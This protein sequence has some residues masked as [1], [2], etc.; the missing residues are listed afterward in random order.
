MAEGAGPQQLEAIQYDGRALRILNQ[1]K[2]PHVVE[3]DDIGSLDDGWRAIREMRVGPPLAHMC[4]H[5]KLLPSAAALIPLMVDNTPKQVRGAPAIAIV[6]GLSLLVEVRKHAPYADRAELQAKVEGL[7]DHLVTARPTAVNLSR[8]AGEVRQL[9]HEAAAAVDGAAAADDA[10]A[11]ETLLARLAS[12]VEG[13]LASDLA[14][15]RNIGR[16]GCEHI[17]GLPGG[18]F[19]GGAGVAVLHICNTGSLATAGYGTALGI[20]R[21]L[22]AAGRLKM[23]YQLETRPYLQGARLS[24]FETMADSIPVTLIT[25]SMAAALLR[26][27]TAEGT[28]T[29]A[30][31]GADRVARNG[32]TANKIGTYALALAAKHHKVPFLV[33][34]PA[35][36]IDLAIASGAD[37]PIEERPADEL[38]KLA[39]VSIAPEQC[40]CWNPAFDVTDAALISG[41]VTERGVATPSV[42]DDSVSFNLEAFLA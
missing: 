34:A 31:C 20:V 24:V 39:G 36:S 38:R 32:D 3:Y 7:L 15:N 12:Y 8:M 33:A 18:G 4:M 13:L 42:G 9:M 19:A 35:T 17:L 23:L 40:L 11:A 5:G 26:K 22:H 25:D 2:L 10:A 30:V 6:G 14:D 28:P 41:I 21:A 16:H 1:L 27:L 37:I 29:V